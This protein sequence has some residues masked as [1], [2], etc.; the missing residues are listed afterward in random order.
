MKHLYEFVYNYRCEGKI[1]GKLHHAALRKFDNWLEVNTVRHES[2][3]MVLRNVLFFG[4]EKHKEIA[5]AFSNNN[6]E[7]LVY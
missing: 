1:E 5:I 7:T 4:D 3:G 2:D 6:G